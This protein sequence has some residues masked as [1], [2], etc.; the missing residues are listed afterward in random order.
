MIIEIVCIFLIAST[1]LV[2]TAMIDVYVDKNN[3]KKN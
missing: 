2:S 1:T 3:L